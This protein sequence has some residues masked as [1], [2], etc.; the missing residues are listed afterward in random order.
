MVN[1]TTFL[2]LMI[3]AFVLPAFAQPNTFVRAK[4]NTKKV[5]VKQPFQLRITVYTPTWFTSAPNLDNIVI[6][7]ALTIKEGRAQSHYETINDI[8]YTTLYFDFIVFPVKEGELVIP[9]MPLKYATPEEG[10][11]KGKE[12]ERKT[13]SVTIM[14]DSLGDGYRLANWL[15]ANSFRVSESWNKD[16]TA[17]KVGDVLER[18]ISINATGT[19]AALIPSSDTLSI[20]WG[21]VYQK[22]PT[23]KTEIADGT[24][25]SQ[26]T[27]IMTF[28]LEE[29]GQYT[30]PEQTFSWWNPLSR[31]TFSKTLP[32][33]KIVIEDNPDLAILKSLQDS[34]DAVNTAGQEE[35][36]EEK[37]FTLFGLRIWQLLIVLGL[38]LVFII[39][40]RRLFSYLKKKQQAQKAI[41]LSSEKYYFEQLKA[42]CRQK[43]LMIIRNQF[44]TWV[45]KLTEDTNIRSL[46]DFILKYGT[47]EMMELHNMLKKRLFGKGD[48][49]AEFSPDK[50][51]EELNRARNRILEDS[52]ATVERHDFEM[53]LN[54]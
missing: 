19:V 6:P 30:I 5:Q 49:G 35:T 18:T 31:K 39:Q 52:H 15:V 9:E 14:V 21:K 28:L 43:D 22:T 20:S 24:I 1:K 41:Y 11:F 32:E 17:A 37:P 44:F 7:G 54:P 40:V 8:R 12:V 50:F 16:I 10:D 46:N 33:R 26:R 42:S 4:A 45:K 51:T 53:Q 29:P 47:P 38:F 3:F 25:K 13:R 36:P 2:I 23:L 34:L 27:E 48:S